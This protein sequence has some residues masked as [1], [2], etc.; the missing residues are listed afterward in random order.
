MS[1]RTL[2]LLYWLWCY[3]ATG[4]LSSPPN[5]NFDLLHCGQLILHPRLLHNLRAGEKYKVV[6]SN[7]HIQ[8]F[9]ATDF[10]GIDALNDNKSVVFCPVTKWIFLQLFCVYICWFFTSVKREEW[11]SLKKILLRFLYKCISSWINKKQFSALQHLLTLN[12]VHGPMLSNYTIT[13]K[14]QRR[15]ILS[16]TAVWLTSRPGIVLFF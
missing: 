9:L 16:F 4:F 8:T 10:L 11:D 13:K 1:W 7:H 12:L 5:L 6:L 14:L 3:Y 15:P 2:C